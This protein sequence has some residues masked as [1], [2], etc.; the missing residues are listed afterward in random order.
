ME[1]TLL[2]L[3]LSISLSLLC[4]TGYY[5]CQTLTTSAITPTN[6][7]CSSPFSCPSGAVRSGR[8]RLTLSQL[9]LLK[10]SGNVPPTAKILLLRH[11]CRGGESMNN[12]TVTHCPYCEPPYDGKYEWRLVAVRSDSNAT[13]Q[14]NSIKA[15]EIFCSKCNTTLSITPLIQR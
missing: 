7:S 15:I 12:Y 5:H 4:T 1:T 10:Q 13:E 6:K 8:L 14:T 2:L 3:V 11:L 9:A